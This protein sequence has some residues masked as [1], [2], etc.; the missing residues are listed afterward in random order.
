MVFLKNIYLTT[1]TYVMS[2]RFFGVLWTKGHPVHLKRHRLDTIFGRVRLVSVA[3][4]V[5]TLCW[6]PVDVLTF[7]KAEAF[8]LSALRVVVALLFLVIAAVPQ[9]DWSPVRVMIAVAIMLLNPLILYAAAE[10]LVGSQDLDG[11]AQ[12]NANLYAALPYVVLVGDRKSVV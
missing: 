3:F 2:P 6:I 8:N 1:M 4:A 5:L 7:A 10:T 11:L 12:V 9:R